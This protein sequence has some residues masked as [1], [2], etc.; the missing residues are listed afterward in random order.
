MA[1]QAHPNIAPSRLT[2]DLGMPP[3]A[4]NT[5]NGTQQSHPATHPASPNIA[6]RCTQPLHP[7]YHNMAPSHDTPP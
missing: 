2:E 3:I 5:A 6:P 7:T 1:H 4:P